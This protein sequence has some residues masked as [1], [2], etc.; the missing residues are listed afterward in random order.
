MK[1]ILIIEDDTTLAEGLCRALSAQDIEVS[2][3]GTLLEARKK[4]QL[5]RQK[6]GKTEDGSLHLVLLDVNLPDGSGF[7]FLKEIPAY[8]AVPVILLTANDMESDMVYGLENGAVDYITK[9][10]SLAVLRARVGA[11]LRQQ[12]MQREKNLQQADISQRENVCQ[13]DGEISE[14]KRVPVCIDDYCFDFERMKFRKGNQ[15]IGSRLY[16]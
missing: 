7:D 4:L 12:E 6:S 11:Q 16:V 15:A 3:C 8:C 14:G 10:F 9:P 13:Q 5:I 2:S 1:K